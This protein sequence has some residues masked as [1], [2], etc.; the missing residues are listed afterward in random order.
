MRERGRGREREKLLVLLSLSVERT[1]SNLKS[2]AKKTPPT[3]TTTTDDLH[4]LPYDFRN[5]R[6]SSEVAKVY[7]RR[8]F[9]AGGLPPLTFSHLKRNWCYLPS[10]EI[11]EDGMGRGIDDDDGM[12]WGTSGMGTGEG[13][14]EW[15][16][17]PGMGIGTQQDASDVTNG[18]GESAPSRKRVSGGSEPRPQVGVVKVPSHQIQRHSGGRGLKRKRTKKA[19]QG[20]CYISLSQRAPSDTR[21]CVCVCVCVCSG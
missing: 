11:K 9:G 13:G 3:N 4:E 1:K 19:L 16:Y 7:N 15:S 17:G 21:A 5:Q 2:K 12:E 14:M 18:D 10:S 8:G 20:V 6:T